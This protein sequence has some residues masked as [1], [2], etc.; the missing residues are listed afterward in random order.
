MKSTPLFQDQEADHK[1]IMILR[2]MSSFR[3]EY[4]L[5]LQNA[6]RAAFMAWIEKMSNKGI[7]DDR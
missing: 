2:N 6:R 7:G 5:D 1:I 3:F 4:P